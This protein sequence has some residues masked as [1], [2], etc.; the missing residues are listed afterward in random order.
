[1]CKRD[2]NAHLVSARARLGL[3]RA[4]AD[5]AVDLRDCVSVLLAE[6][7]RPSPYPMS[8]PLYR[9]IG[10]PG[11]TVRLDNTWSPQPI[12]R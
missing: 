5:D 1:M 2:W 10:V 4:P 11:V 6:L 9:T 3:S 12:N 8:P 7:N